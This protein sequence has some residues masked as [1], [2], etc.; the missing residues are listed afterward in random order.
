M[1]ACWWLLP[2]P[3]LCKTV[4]R[5][6]KV[7]G[8]RAVEGPGL[9]Q[10]HR[11]EVVSGQ[12]AAAPLALVRRGETARRGR[13]HSARRSYCSRSNLVN[14]FALAPGVAPV[15]SLYRLVHFAYDIRSPLALVLANQLLPD[16]LAHPVHFRSGARCPN[17]TEPRPQM[18]GWMPERER[19]KVAERFCAF[20]MP[21][22]HA[23]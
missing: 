13:R 15:P 12:R 6:M 20:L 23:K 22:R 4:Q 3:E 2:G 11:P 7:H 19:H 5:G 16:A 8:W 10:P 1:L 9:S 21:R 17:L 14:Q 18:R